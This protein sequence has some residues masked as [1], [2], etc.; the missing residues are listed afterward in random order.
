[1]A[2]NRSAPFPTNQP[3]YFDGA[4]EQ[5]VRQA[6]QS[7]F[8]G[9]HRDAVASD[10]CQQRTSQMSANPTCGSRIGDHEF[11]P[12]PQ[13]CPPTN[14]QSFPRQTQS[15]A[16]QNNTG[17]QCTTTS[18]IQENL[19]EDRSAAMQETNASDSLEGAFTGLSLGPS[20]RELVPPAESTSLAAALATRAAPDSGCAE[21]SGV[22]STLA[23][24]E[25]AQDMSGSIGGGESDTRPFRRLVSQAR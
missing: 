1:M 16:Q 23:S 6:T 18:T 20:A 15:N 17:L 14:I 4:Q 13:Y 3:I 21:S 25:C 22:L 9:L 11:R 2:Y 10:P 5:S 19:F 8:S 7:I 12:C 24:P